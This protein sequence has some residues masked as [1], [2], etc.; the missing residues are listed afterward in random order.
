MSTKDPTNMKKNS[1]EIV[2]TADS[3]YIILRHTQMAIYT[4]RSPRTSQ[5]NSKAPGPFLSVPVYT[6]QQNLQTSIPTHLWCRPG[7][8]Q[9]KGETFERLQ[10][11][12]GL[13]PPPI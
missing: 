3:F 13:Y 8:E 10:D 9:R 1:I 2:E 11:T 6:M 12:G 5:K 4:H 7:K